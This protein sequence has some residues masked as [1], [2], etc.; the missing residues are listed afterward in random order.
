MPKVSM[1]RPAV[2]DLFKREKGGRPPEK[3]ELRET[4]G[5]VSDTPRDDAPAGSGLKQDE[6]A[7]LAALGRAF[8]E[9]LDLPEGMTAAEAAEAVIAMWES[10]EGAEAHAPAGQ[11]A[12]AAS[13]A[14]EANAADEAK[15]GETAAK[16]GAELP[17]PVRGELAD[18]PEPDYSRMSS[19][20][21]RKLKKQLARASMDG[22][23]IRI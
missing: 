11:E 19:E 21:F 13:E 12:T 15:G 10:G 3:G 5:P 20:Q 14:A 9:R 1:K 18:A 7:A 23:R 17:L 16:R 22:L 2:M 4:D 6:D 8:I